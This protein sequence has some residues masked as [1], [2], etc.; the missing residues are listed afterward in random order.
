M[1]LLYVSDFRRKHGNQSIIWEIK[2]AMKL[3]LRLG[4][5][6]FTTRLARKCVDWTV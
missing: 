5:S 1:N 2:V 4:F 6:C 3:R